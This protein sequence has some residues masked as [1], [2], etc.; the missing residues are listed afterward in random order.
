MNLVTVFLDDA[1]DTRIRGFLG[2]AGVTPDY[3]LRDPDMRLAD[4]YGIDAVPALLV[5]DAAGSIVLSRSGYREEERDDLYR[6]LEL[7][8]RRR[9]R[10]AA[11]E[12]SSGGP[13]PA[14]GSLRVPARGKTGVRPALPGADSRDAAR[15]PVRHLRIAEAALAAGRRDLALRSLARYLAASPRP[16]TVRTSG[17][18]SPGCSPPDPDRRGARALARARRELVAPL[19][20][21]GRRI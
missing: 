1:P 21:A 17:R 4:R 9:A 12:P 3:V 18:R 7:R 2:A 10:A 15:L 11:V 14:R 16:T 19:D 20:T 8:L 13:P 6:D 5:I